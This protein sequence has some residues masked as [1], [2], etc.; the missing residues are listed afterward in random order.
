MAE[1]TASL[2]NHIIEVQKSLSNIELLLVRTYWRNSNH[3]R[4]HQNIHRYFTKLLQKKCTKATETKCLK[5]LWCTALNPGWLSTVASQSITKPRVMDTTAKEV[6][7]RNWTKSTRLSIKSQSSKESAFKKLCP[8]FDWSFFLTHNFQNLEM[9]RY[10]CAFDSLGVCGAFGTWI[11][12]VCQARIKSGAFCQNTGMGLR[13]ENMSWFA[14]FWCKSGVCRKSC[15]CFC[16][17]PQF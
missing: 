14:P 2:L 4:C 3:C 5:V 7:F 6:T 8:I 10:F 9:L 12:S 11:P 16:L 17:I 15:Y 13:L 1:C